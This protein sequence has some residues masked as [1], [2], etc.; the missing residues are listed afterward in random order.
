M[1]IARQTLRE[2]TV[3]AVRDQILAGDLEPGRVLREVHLAGELGVSRTPLREALLEL[4]REGLTRKTVG[5][6]FVVS[7][8]EAR[9]VHELYP[10]RA[11]LESEALREAGLPSDERLAELAR[12]NEKLGTELPGQDW[13]RLDNRWHELLVESC[14]NR[15]LRDFVQRLRKHTLRYELAFLADADAPGPSIRQHEEI[16]DRLREGDLDSACQKLAEN[17]TVGIDALLEKLEAREKL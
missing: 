9:E 17:M 13:I 4:T 7:P 5:H 1:K 10:L 14:G 15:H 3:D 11:L 6:G 12:L 8:L 2:Q 16:L